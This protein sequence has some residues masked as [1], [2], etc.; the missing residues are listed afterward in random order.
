MRV[1]ARAGAWASQS[2]VQAASP[3]VQGLRTLTVL[4]NQASWQSTMSFS[5]EAALRGIHTSSSA[6]AEPVAVEGDVSALLKEIDA[7]VS[8]EAVSAKEVADA[9]VALTYVQAKS[10]RR[11]WGKVVEKAGAVKATF[12]AAS[13]TNLLWALTASG[14]EHFKTVAELAGPAAELLP[15]MTP[16]QVSLVVEALGKAGVAD[17]ALQA[18]V[19]AVV[20]AKIGEYKPADLA[21]V[22]FGVAASGASDVQLTKAISKAL[23][24]AELDSR[25]AAQSLYALAVLRRADTATVAALSKSLKG[26]ES[27]VDA[28]AAAWSLGALAA[29][30]DRST[31]AALASALKASAGDLS[32]AQAVQAAWGLGLIGAADKEAVSALFAVAAA[33]IE[34]APESISP[35]LLAQLHEAAV[36]AP[37]AKL[38]AAVAEFAGKAFGLAVDATRLK[39]TS[40]EAAFVADVTEATARAMG[41][42]YR[43]E[44]ADLA[45]SFAKTAADGSGL[46]I[47]VDI[48]GGKLLVEP[49][50]A[51]VLSTSTPVQP[52][53]AAQAYAKV[54]EA[55][56]YK[57]AFVPVSEWQTLEDAKA[58]ATFVLSAVKKAVPGLSSRVD[59]LQK[60][61][62]EPFN[63]YA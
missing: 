52:L 54:R 43:P 44:I 4:A 31:G 15:T 56:G 62:E 34:K 7:I 59:S 38:P 21:R 9:A 14:V 32:A 19:S 25:V 22:L 24:G 3:A 20:L 40:A 16:T 1:L 39:R 57:V 46:D 35:A 29:K 41:A 33:A 48:E 23:A 53:G 11:V 18:K 63:P 6:H 60:K 28:A 5:A 12:D 42:R 49:L 8:S 26:F 10:N 55:Q 13:L 30:V 58:K 2:A 36:L 17:A 27:G 51:A 47:A 37:E 50:P 45:K 61:L